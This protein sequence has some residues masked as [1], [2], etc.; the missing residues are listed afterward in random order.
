MLSTCQKPQTTSSHCHPIINQRA[1]SPDRLLRNSHRKT[2]MASPPQTVPSNSPGVSLRRE[3]L[4]CRAPGRYPN[5]STTQCPPTASTSARGPSGSSV[6]TTVGRLTASNRS[7]HDSWNRTESF[8][9]SR[10]LYFLLLV[11]VCAYC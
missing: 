6:R 1:G 11:I 10:I 9:M 2:K 4:Y 5:S 8:T 7:V 3:R